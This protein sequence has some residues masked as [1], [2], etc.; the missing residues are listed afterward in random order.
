MEGSGIK[1]SRWSPVA[2]A[3]RRHIKDV[4]HALVTRRS[5]PDRIVDRWGEDTSGT[6]IRRDRGNHED[7]I[8]DS[9]D[10]PASRRPR[11]NRVINRRDDRTEMCLRDDNE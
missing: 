2:T 6:A 3:K 1:H 7:A 11:S 10:A 9:A 5:E 4:A 8:N